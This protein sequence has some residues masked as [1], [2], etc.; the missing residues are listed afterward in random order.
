MLQRQLP[1]FRLQADERGFVNLAGISPVE[2]FLAATGKTLFKGL[3]FDDLVRLVARVGA[4][5]ACLKTDAGANL[6]VAYRRAAN[7]LRDEENRDKTSYD[8]EPN[9]KE[10]VTE[11]ERQLFS[12]L[13][14]ASQRIRADAIDR[15]RDARPDDRDRA[16]AA[17]RQRPARGPGR[18]GVGPGSSRLMPQ[19]ARLI[20]TRARVDATRSRPRRTW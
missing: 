16:A 6:L 7:V 17:A 2:Q 11:E 19:L 9:P 20:G 18:P 10:F 14:E 3:A 8:G 13:G 5:Q 12:L 1:A 15:R 4:L